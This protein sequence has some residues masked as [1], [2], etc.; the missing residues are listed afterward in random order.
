MTIGQRIDHLRYERNMSIDE[1]ATKAHVSKNTIVGWIYRGCHP[2]IE[3]LICVAD[4]L[5]ISL[6]DL[7]GRK[8]TSYT[9]TKKF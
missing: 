6:D 2:D 9:K 1:L 4:V 7:C 8:E 3:L 5:Q